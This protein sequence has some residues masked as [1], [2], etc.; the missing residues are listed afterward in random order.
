VLAGEACELRRG[1][2]APPVG[3]QGHSLG[4]LAAH[5]YGQ[6]QLCAFIST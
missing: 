6:L 2:L 4:E 5:R 1:V 3:A